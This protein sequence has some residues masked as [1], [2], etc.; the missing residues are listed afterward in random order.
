MP[1]RRPHTSSN[2]QF[3]QSQG[4]FSQGNILSH[5]G[6]Q[7]Q[8]TSDAL[9]DENIQSQN[10]ILSSTQQ[11]VAGVKSN[12]VKYGS[13]PLSQKSLPTA[14]QPIQKPLVAAK[15]VN[16]DI[17]DHA[18]SQLEEVVEEEIIEEEEVV[19]EE[20]HSGN[21]TG[22]SAQ[23]AVAAGESPAD[24]ATTKSFSKRK[25][26]KVAQ[27][28]AP[29]AAVDASV[30]LDA[31]AKHIA[32]QGMFL[33][34][35]AF[36]ADMGAL[37]DDLDLILGTNTAKSVTSASAAGKSKAKDAHGHHSVGDDADLSNAEEEESFVAVATAPGH[38]SASVAK[39]ETR[40]RG[41]A[42]TS[43]AYSSSFTAAPIESNATTRRR[44][45]TDKQLMRMQGACYNDADVAWI[46]QH[47]EEIEAANTAARKGEDPLDFAEKLKKKESKPSDV[48]ETST[49]SS[50]SSSSSSSLSTLEKA[51]AK[52][53]LG[54]GDTGKRDYRSLALPHNEG[55]WMVKFFDD[56]EA[57]KQNINIAT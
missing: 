1:P 40:N 45:V 24:E 19:V 22:T 29:D 28:D 5:R 36:D 2:L 37:N 11:M 52:V 17:F 4:H 27:D 10:A 32:E 14:S 54:S 49:S 20:L 21:A 30:R 56:I 6:S 48:S 35:P 18:A 12:R 8:G 25:G 57:G 3:S 33:D 51:Q 53:S 41:S 44:R 16:T 42:P 26:H 23:V 43:S 34:D 46:A 38:S 13:L 31:K 9:D 55:D 7:S 39:R 15:D 50:S 47:I